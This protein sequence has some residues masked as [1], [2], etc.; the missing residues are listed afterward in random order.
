MKITTLARTLLPFGAALALVACAEEEETTYE[1]DTEDLSGGELQVA[2][3]A[4]EGVEVDLPETPMT[5]ASQEEIE[6]AA[7]EDEAAE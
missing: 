6:A 1:A 7:E 5:N 4:A 2:D 3:P